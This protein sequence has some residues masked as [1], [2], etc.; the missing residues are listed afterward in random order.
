MC[1]DLKK[2]E[3]VY[4]C[5]KCDSMSCLSLSRKNYQRQNLFKGNH[6]T[7]NH[8]N[9]SFIACLA[10]FN[11]RFISALTPTLRDQNIKINHKMSRNSLNLFI[12][13]FSKIVWHVSL[14]MRK[15]DCLR[16]C[17]QIS[18]ISTMLKYARFA[19]DY[20][21]RITNC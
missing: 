19:L 12:F 1:L 20:Y 17:S 11:L 16:L 14:I 10:Y 5:H 7:A 3:K 21:E 15:T 13:L 9:I 2:V 6:K 18:S 8:V 4:T